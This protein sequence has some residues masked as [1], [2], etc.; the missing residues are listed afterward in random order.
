MPYRRSVWI[1]VFGVV[2]FGLVL[3]GGAGYLLSNMGDLTGS[4]GG[5]GTAIASGDVSSAPRAESGLRT[6]HSA[7]ASRSPSIIGE[8][9]PVPS[10]SG[11]EAPFSDS[12]RSQATPDLTGPTGSSVGGP[13]GASSSNGAVGRRT[14]ESTGPTIA[15]RGSQNGIAGGATRSQGASEGAIW[16]AEAQNLAGRA[17]ALSNQLGQIERQQGRSA[18]NRR[19][20]SSQ[21]DPAARTSSGQGSASTSSNPGT[22]D[23]PDQV[24]IGGLGWL[25]AT[26]V[27]YGAYRLRASSLS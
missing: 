14:L 17:R 10:G 11:V 22:P 9:A 1:D 18:S 4:S 13:S 3:L 12:W 5:G 20:E 8:G 25:L 19:A 15:S 7:P 27:G 16:Q 2:L 24:P 23:N 6:R 21:K 26:G